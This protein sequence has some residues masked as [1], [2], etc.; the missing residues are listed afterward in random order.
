MKS[1]LPLNCQCNACKTFSIKT[2]EYDALKSQI[3]WFG[4][5][6]LRRAWWVKALAYLREIWQGQA[7]MSSSS[8]S[9]LLAY[10]FN[11]VLSNI[12]L[13]FSAASKGRIIKCWYVYSSQRNRIL[14]SYRRNNFNGGI[15]RK[16]E[17]VCTRY[18]YIDRTTDKYIQLTKLSLKTSKCN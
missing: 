13:S 5:E 7:F 16:A 9:L 17:Q 11:E 6:S 15:Y 12:T 4:I 14:P 8:L 3:R 10:S 2:L 18:R 1:K